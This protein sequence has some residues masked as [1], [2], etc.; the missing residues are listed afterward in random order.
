MIEKL[1][2][3]EAPEIASGTV[4]IKAVAREPGS[5]AKVA[6]FS[7]DEHI[8][9]IGSCVGQ[10]GVRVSTVMSEIGGEKIDLILWSEDATK[11]IADALSPARTQGVVLNEAE[12]YATVT[13]A[14]DQQSLAIGRGGQNVRLAAKL[15]GWRLDIVSGEGETPV[16]VSEEAD[17]LT[18]TP[19]E[20]N[21]QEDGGH[22]NE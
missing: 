7:A 16:A 1:F 12:H 14:P 2:A 20:I 5:R 4:E 17:V 10:R 22:A 21:S 11:F 19:S 9:P 8:D 15:T 3:Q 18:E 6:V 13:V